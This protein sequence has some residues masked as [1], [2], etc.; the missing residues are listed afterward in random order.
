MS[1]II[2][3]ETHDVK[4][5]VRRLKRLNSTIEVYDNGEYTDCTEYSQVFINST[6]TEAEIENWLW[7]YS[8]CDYVGVVT[9]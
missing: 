5:L 1:Y 6:K 7:Q 4:R 2:D 3:V 9:L 8:N